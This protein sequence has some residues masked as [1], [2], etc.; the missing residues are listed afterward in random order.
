[1]RSPRHSTSN[2]EEEEDEVAT[3]DDTRG[4]STLR[5]GGVIG[6]QLAPILPPTTGARR[7]NELET[8]M[9]AT[10]VERKDIRRMTA[11]LKEKDRP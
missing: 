2:K 9:T 3:R 5:G 11:L 8:R 4:M 6:V 10:I 7:T 1:M